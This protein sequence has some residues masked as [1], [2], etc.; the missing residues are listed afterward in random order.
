MNFTPQRDARPQPS[1]AKLITAFAAIYLLWGS[2]YLAIHFAVETLPPFLMAGT[3]H[4]VAG[5]VLYPLARLRNGER[6]TRAN[7]SAAFLMGALLLFGGNGGV[8]WAEKIVP[9]GVAALLVAT[10]PLWMVLFDW[11]RPGGL[12]PT[13]RVVIGLFLG[14]AGVAFLVGPSKLAGG[15]RVDPIG[16]TV[17][18]LASL[19]WAAGSVFSRHLPLPRSPLLGT[20]M[21]CFIGGALLIV[22]GLLAGQGSAL[23]WESV[24]L[25][26][27]LALGYLI[28]F[29]SLLGFSAYIWLLGVAPPARVSTYAYVNPVVAL[30]LAG[31]WRASR[32]RCACWWPRRSSSPRWCW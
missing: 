30:V 8:S 24:S 16:A 32:S 3:R 10:V 6:L 27:V 20:A 12:R 31:R 7:W 19:S 13:G 28:M 17:L 25:R 15:G 29:G 9:S 26:S 4:L 22:V 5:A 18:I 21:Q 23:R 1:T 14:F 2:T 11:L